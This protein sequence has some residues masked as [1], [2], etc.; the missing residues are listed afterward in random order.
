MYGAVSV[1][2]VPIASCN[3]GLIMDGFASHATDKI[4]VVLVTNKDEKI[5]IELEK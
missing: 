1:K 5:T 4:T 2:M 3:A